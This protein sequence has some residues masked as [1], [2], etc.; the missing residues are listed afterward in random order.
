LGIKSSLVFVP[1]RSRIAGFGFPFLRAAN[2]KK[3][4][5]EKKKK[6]KKERKKGKIAADRCR[7]R[8]VVPTQ[9]QDHHSSS[10]AKAA[11]NTIP[12]ITFD[13]F[14][15]SVA[16]LFPFHPFQTSPSYFSVFLTPPT[17][18]SNPGQGS[19]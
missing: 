6:K 4:A 5:R 2:P 19:G 18:L 16:H 1:F 3:K 13:L 7:G 10:A 12:V 11:K 14:V 8:Q 15:L 17:P 9:T